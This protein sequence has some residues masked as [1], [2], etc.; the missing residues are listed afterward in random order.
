MITKATIKKL[1]TNENNHCLVFIPFLKKAND[2]TDDATLEATFISISGIENTYKV[3]DVV[4]VEFEDNEY[5]RP[6]IIGKLYTDKEN[7]DEITTTIIAKASQITTTS[8]LPDSTYLGDSASDSLITKIERAE[9]LS[10]SNYENKQDKLISGQTIKTINNESILGSGNINISGGSGEID[11]AK[12]TS[13]TLLGIVGGYIQVG[14]LAAADKVSTVQ[15]DDTLL[16]IVNR[17]MNE[18]QF[19]FDSSTNTYSLRNIYGGASTDTD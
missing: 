18:T 17:K 7:A 19:E 14:D 1:N 12:T 16:N 10:E 5:S 15:L 8:K 4:Y 3:G 13:G 6:V 11:G 2:M 9:Y